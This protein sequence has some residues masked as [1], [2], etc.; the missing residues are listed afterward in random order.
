M[1]PPLPSRHRPDRR[2]YAFITIIFMAAA[3]AI[4]LALAL[5][6]VAMQAQRVR[7]ERLIYRG[8]QYKRAIE[9]YFRKHKK[10]PSEMD[11]LEDTNGVRFLRRR[12]K[13]PMNPAEDE[14]R[15]IHMGP[16]GSFKDSLIYDLKEEEDQQNAGRSGGMQPSASIGAS[17]SQ[18]RQGGYQSGYPGYV[19][20]DGRFRGGDRARNAR[21]S[22]APEIP[23]QGAL[24]PGWIP[25][26]SPPPDPNQP[27]AV[28]EYGNP[29]PP[30][31]QAQGGAGRQASQN[32]YPGY[33]RTLPSQ[34]PPNQPGQQRRQQSGRAQA[35][36]NQL[37]YGQAG[38]AGTPSAPQPARSASAPSAFG[39]PGAFG[40]QGGGQAA[41]IIKGLLTT[42]RPGGLAGI[43][44]R[45]NRSQQGSSFKGG[46]AGVASKAEEQGVKIYEG[47]EYFNEWE[48]V[49]DY[50][51]DNAFGG[52]AMGPQMAAAGG[53]QRLPAGQPGTSAAGGLGATPTPAGYGAVPGAAG[54]FG[55]T[56]RG[57]AGY[58]P[59][60]PPRGGSR[61]GSGSRSRPS[62]Y[63]TLRSG[64]GGINTNPRQPG[65]TRNLPPGLPGSSF[66][67]TTIQPL[68]GQ[69]P[70]TGQPGTVFG[71]NGQPIPAPPG[72]PTNRPGRAPAP[73]QYPFL[74]NS[75]P[76]PQPNRNR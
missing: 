2:G 9:I 28:D 61:P 31:Q 56:P 68:P 11:D 27:L 6:R 37:G 51:S 50:R 48:F 72:S 23:G 54:A 69:Q 47:R 60:T 55:Q 29:I 24:I 59:S 10:Y 21:E 36:R 12:Y 17:P 52:A 4:T 49:Y 66:P 65:G 58:S 35:G 5:P 64:R 75:S 46:I 70:G 8:N 13:D 63:D 43:R 34:M 42:P 41:D 38:S 19:P 20:N 74:Q 57:R 73:G 62:P 32:Q 22:A 14:W 40:A 39:N 3:M 16:D 18:L 33:S 15:I 71:P 45:Q 30:G 44:G 7:E 53:S 76:R 25:G 67:P 26:Q 1:R